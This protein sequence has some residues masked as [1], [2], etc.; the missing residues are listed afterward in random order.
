MRHILGIYSD[1]RRQTASVCI[2][3]K[4]KP[5]NYITN[6]R[7]GSHI[8]HTEGTVEAGYK[9]RIIVECKVQHS[10]SKSHAVNSMTQFR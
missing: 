3:E 7:L 6:G 1:G 2:Y 10:S 9:G 5:L 4:V 8:G